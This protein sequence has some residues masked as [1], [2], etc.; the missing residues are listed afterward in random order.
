MIAENCVSELRHTFC[1][2]SFVQI[3]I[4]SVWQLHLVESESAFVGADFRALLNFLSVLNR[5]EVCLGS[6]AHFLLG[7]LELIC[8]T[9]A[10]L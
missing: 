4:I 5:V 8:N 2:F 3:C 1:W 9:S 7:F 10:L 6:E